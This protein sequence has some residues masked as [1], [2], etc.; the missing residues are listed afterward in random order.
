MLS[1]NIYFGVVFGI[2]TSFLG[3]VFGIV[4][5]VF[6]IVGVVFGIVRPQL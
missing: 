4:G 1:I 6:G 5:V 3:V 2:I